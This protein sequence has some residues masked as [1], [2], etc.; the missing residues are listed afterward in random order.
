MNL[1]DILASDQHDF[2]VAIIGISCRLPK[3]N[4]PDE[5]WSNLINSKD[6]IHFFSIDQLDSSIASKLKQDKHYV[7]A[8]GYVEGVDQF[9]ADFFGFSQ[10]EAQL[11]DPQFRLFFECAWETFEDAGYHPRTLDDKVG[12]FCSA[13]MSLYSGNR[14]NDY[15][16]TVVNKDEFINLFE[17]PQVIIANKAEYL[18]TRI[19][20]KFNLKGPSVNI[21]TAC[22]SSLVAVHTA[23]QSLLNGESDMAI[24]GAAAIHF[25]NK[26]GYLFYE[27]GMY[28]SDGYCKTFSN[29]ADGI[30]G[31]NGVGVVLMKRLKDAIRDKDNIHAI[32]RGSAINNDG[33]MKVSYMA[34][35]IQGQ[36]DVLK[37]AYKVSGVIPSHVGYIE[38]HGTGTRMGDPIEVAALSQVFHEYTTDLQYC[39]IG[40]V[41]TSIGHLDTAAGMAS[42]IKTTLSLKHKVIP[43]TLHYE[44]SNA[45]INFIGSPFFVNTQP[46]A[47]EKREG[48]R[49][50]G[51]SA[52]GAG[53]TNAHIV[54]EEFDHPEQSTTAI[55]PF[56]FM[57]LSAKTN[58]ALEEYLARYA[59]YLNQHAPKID[60]F[61]FT[62]NVSRS[63]HLYRA[64]FVFASREEL[65]EK[66][67]HYVIDHTKTLP[68]YK[69]N[70]N[71]LVY[72]FSGQGSQYTGMGHS[73]YNYHS[74]FKIA[75]DEC[76]LLLEQ[77]LGIDIRTVLWG[78]ATN[79]LDSTQYTQPALFVIGY[80]LSVLWR[81]WGLLPSAVLGHS[82]GEYI[83]ACVAGVMSL[84]NSLRLI[85]ARGRLMQNLPATGGMCVVFAT[86]AIVE[87]FLNKERL[88]SIAAI[89]G[90]ENTV[91]SGDKSSLK[92]VVQKL[93]EAGFTCHPLTVSHAFHSPLME[94]ILSDFRKIAESISY[95]P[96]QILSISN[97]TGQAVASNEIN[98]DYWVKHI[99]A[100]VN[101]AAGM[102]YL[103]SK[104]YRE[105]IE[106]G[107]KA[108]LINMGRSNVTAAEEACWLSSLSEKEEIKTLLQSLGILY[109]RG[110]KIYWTGYYAKTNHQKISLP[111]YP[112]QR[113]RYWVDL[114][115]QLENKNNFYKLHW[116]PTELKIAERSE[117][118][119]YLILSNECTSAEDF[120]SLFRQKNIDS[121]VVG[122]SN[123]LVFN[124]N[125]CNFD[126]SN[127]L[128]WR[129]F[130]DEMTKY[131]RNIIFIYY[132]VVSPMEK[133]N[134]EDMGFFCSKIYPGYLCLLKLE[135]HALANHV[136]DIILIYPALKN[137]SEYYAAPYFSPLLGMRQ[138]ALAEANSLGL[139]S[140]G[141]ATQ[142]LDLSKI[143][144]LIVNKVKSTHVILEDEIYLS[145]YLSRHLPQNINNIRITSEGYYLITGGL[146]A[147]GLLFSEYLVE[148]GAKKL[149]LIS[150]S[151]PT[152]KTIKRIEAL[153]KRQV[154]VQVISLDIA[155]ANALQESILRITSKGTHITGVIH[156]AGVINDKL[157]YQLDNETL[158]AP[159]Y[160]K[161]YGSINLIDSLNIS[162]L[163]FFVNF[164]SI[165]SVMGSP[166]QINYAASNAFLDAFA[167]YLNSLGVNSTTINWGPWLNVGMSSQTT[168]LKGNHNASSK[169]ISVT[170]I[171]GKHAFDAVLADDACQLIKLDMG[172]KNNK[173]I[174]SLDIDEFTRSFWLDEFHEE[175]A[176]QQVKSYSSSQIKDIILTSVKKVIGK[177]IN[178]SAKDG[179]QDLGMDSMMGLQF[180]N[181]LSKELPIHL[182]AIL[183]YK[184]N[185]VEE[186]HEY[187]VSN[188]INSLSQS[189]HMLEMTDEDV[190]NCLLDELK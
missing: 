25:P 91:I 154:E 63:Y 55:Q 178:F 43:A 177:E 155:D 32:I 81:S 88:L 142:Q 33:D 187:L 160:P 22:S 99:L 119:L 29:K 141:Y 149:V 164:S 85:A 28:A 106:L 135:E 71:R 117:N 137:K 54:L 98:A 62:T 73:L 165:A 118:C 107:P 147:L 47:W 3:A 140:I 161:I 87:S 16:S 132:P 157:L 51:V 174:E 143:M 171:E 189:A 12:V 97:L 159:M 86:R 34:P 44:H 49:Y 52:L 80:G 96:P 89:N 92:R 125:T 45:A 21:Q 115:E 183:I 46:I 170:A 121:L 90:V 60:A 8:T 69:D 139:K 56:Y 138:A 7:P 168:A 19:S 124:D 20:Y 156:A 24:A 6:C 136:K 169:L 15:F 82:V 53:G 79:L 48:T 158:T 31:G 68:H 41:K 105:Y 103:W 188:M 127:E 1:D 75:I 17:G 151:T 58:H 111:T 133:L 84:Q 36:V 11:L 114:A 5:F 128:H 181:I 50:A 182:P 110:C 40:S 153:R 72:L 131:K 57:T 14:M 39:S 74:A 95:Q 152:E 179:F 185:N 70:S 146:G 26:A 175:K 27:G 122:L 166:G 162:Q 102:N 134:Q 23:C 30:V 9:D 108:T 186:L 13:G 61:A 104:N 66:L 38:A 109:V 180:R 130:F 167:Y 113:K 116:K 172:D 2:S 4:N 112:F 150:R 184:Y 100:P 42:L 129:L 163:D 126:F 10:Q 65:L 18:P 190:I 120:S 101:F 78:E 35:S 176:S 76:A 67:N 64:S 77:D 148:K 123:E 93:E 144:Q 83:A 145:P 94:P 37:Q 59:K 173:N